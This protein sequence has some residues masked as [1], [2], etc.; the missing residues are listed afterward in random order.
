MMN[1]ELI[2]ATLE[3]S[4]HVELERPSGERVV[5]SIVRATD[6]RGSPYQRD[7]LLWLGLSRLWRL[8]RRDHR[9]YVEVSDLPDERK[10]RGDVQVVESSKRE[11]IRSGL[12]VA[13]ELQ[14]EGA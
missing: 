10:G 9:W 4:G 2:R 14:R 3:V 7:Y 13:V 1:E 12:E 6:W 11:A 5:V 8:V